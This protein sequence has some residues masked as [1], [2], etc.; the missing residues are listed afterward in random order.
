MTLDKELVYG[1]RPVKLTQAEIHLTIGGYKGTCGLI[2]IDK[3]E[4]SGQSDSIRVS[5]NLPSLKAISSQWWG[6]R[7][8]RSRDSKRA[9]SPG[10]VSRCIRDGRW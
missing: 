4:L 7:T 8:L 2:P 6:F 3:I 5:S 10:E 9:R 1:N